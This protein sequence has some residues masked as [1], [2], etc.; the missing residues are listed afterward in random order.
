LNTSPLEVL[1]TIDGMDQMTA[2]RLV[3]NRPYDGLQAVASKIGRPINLTSME[4]ATVSTPVLRITLWHPDLALSHEMVVRLLPG[5]LIE[6]SRP[7][8]IEY[9]L[10]VPLKK[11]EEH[12]ESPP[13]KYFTEANPG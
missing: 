3:E 7:W 1:L 4:V 10:D 6:D 9:E 13:G 5:A 11:T 8:I 12:A 2:K